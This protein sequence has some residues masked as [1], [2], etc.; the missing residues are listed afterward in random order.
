ME[1]EE[2]AASIQ[3]GQG[4]AGNEPQENSIGPAVARVQYPIVGY[5]DS[6]VPDTLADGS[7][8]AVLFTHGESKAKEVMLPMQ[9]VTK[10]IPAWFS[11]CSS[12]SFS[13]GTCTSMRS[14][15]VYGS[16]RSD[17]ANS[18]ILASFMCG[19]SFS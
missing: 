2:L 15:A 7:Y 8:E 9:I 14:S 13:R 19:I 12:S 5:V 16:A 3:S 6:H 4:S 11:A 1:L 18:L 17:G 10:G